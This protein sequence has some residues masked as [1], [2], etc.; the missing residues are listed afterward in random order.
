MTEHC[1]DTVHHTGVALKGSTS[2]HDRSVVGQSMSVM[3]HNGP[4]SGPKD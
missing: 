3:E 2:G 4:V 1:N